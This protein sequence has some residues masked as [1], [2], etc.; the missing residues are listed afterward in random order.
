MPT[1]NHNAYPCRP[2]RQQHQT[3][4]KQ[5]QCLPWPSASPT[6]SN[7]PQTT[8]NTLFCARQQPPSRTLELLG[9]LAQ[10]D[11]ADDARTALALASLSPAGL[12]EHLARLARW[13]ARLAAG[14]ARAMARGLEDGALDDPADAGGTTAQIDA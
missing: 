2:H 8:S 11:R 6:T 4:R 12:A 5:P 9:L 1:H 13:R 3:T 14:G 7:N 10:L